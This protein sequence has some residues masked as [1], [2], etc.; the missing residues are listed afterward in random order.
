MALCFSCHKSSSY[1]FCMCMAF[2]SDEWSSTDRLNS[3]S[4]KVHSSE[5]P[6]FSLCCFFCGPSVTAYTCMLSRSW[7]KDDPLYYWSRATVSSSLTSISELTSIKLFNVTAEVSICSTDTPTPLEK[8][9]SSKNNMKLCLQTT[10]GSEQ[11]TKRAR[12]NWNNGLGTSIARR[13]VFFCF[14]RRNYGTTI[15]E[16]PCA[17][18]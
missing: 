13:A 2:V 17:D 4:K 10:T 6:P 18:S 11:R 3:L 14:A 7:S 1:T 16:I 5:G 12:N 8:G 9:R 15:T